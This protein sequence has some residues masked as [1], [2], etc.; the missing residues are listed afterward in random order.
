KSADPN[1]VLTIPTLD[2]ESVEEFANRV[3]AAWKLG[4][5]G[6]D[7]GVLVVVAPQDR[8]M[9]IEVGDGLERTL[10]DVAASR[11]IRNVTPPAFKNGELRPRDRGRCRGYRR[12]ARRP[13]GDGRDDRVVRRPAPP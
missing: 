4:Q 9:R 5:K 11:I 3:F 12:A 10:T 13:A 8:K 6:K 7:N 1:V 2:G